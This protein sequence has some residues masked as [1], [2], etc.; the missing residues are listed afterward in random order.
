MKRVKKFS[1][2]A[3][4][5]AMILSF[6]GCGFQSKNTSSAAAKSS[7]SS[8]LSSSAPV[9]SGISTKGKLALPYNTVP[10]FNP[11][12]P[13]SQMNMNLWPLIYDCL[14]EPDSNYNPVMRL[15]ESVQCDGTEVTIRLKSGVQFSDG[16]SFGADDVCYTFR[17]VLQHNESPYHSRLSNISSINGDGLTV[18]ITL[19]TPDPL[20]ANMLDVPIIKSES[21]KQGNAIGTGRY[22]YS[23]NGVN[24]KL[25]LNDKWYKGTK[26][27]FKTISLVNI[28]N[29]DSVLNTLSINEINYVYS[30][31]GDGTAAAQTNVKTAPVNLNRLV[32]VGINSSREHL[33]NAHFRRALSYTINR[34]TLASQ[35]YSN[36]A[37]ACLVPFN[38]S[39]QKVK[40]PTDKEKSSDYDTA[41]NEIY[42]AGGTGTGTSFT[43]LVN[44]E[45]SVRLAAANLVASS[46][47]KTGIGVHVKSVSFSDYSKMISQGNFDMYIG[48][49]KLSNNMDITPLLAPGGSAAYGVA[50]NSDTLMAFNEW[51]SGKRDIESVAETFKTEMPFIPLCF[52]MGTTS[53]T[54][55][56]TG[57]KATDGDIFYDFEKWNRS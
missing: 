53:F 22:V 56:I 36:R 17:Y 7:A 23:K 8:E 31:S 48:E 4:V 39:W 42:Y 50:A 54:D 35:T 46:F 49:V 3:V 21:D 12:I 15:A 45:N 34:A 2:F 41:S 1:V 37:A 30:D 55:G 28:P 11:L 33:N 32:Y 44:K 10:S 6:A 25:T 57:V 14:A 38:P 40:A 18:A 47:S 51:R 29:P 52:R 20:F 43:L 5:A 26:S 19:K 13:A 9:K 24:A 16:T 27:S